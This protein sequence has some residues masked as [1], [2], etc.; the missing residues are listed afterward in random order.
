MIDPTKATGFVRI[1]PK[2]EFAADYSDTKA[3]EVLNNDEKSLVCKLF[4]SQKK[5]ALGKCVDAKTLRSKN[6]QFFLFLSKNLHPTLSFIFKP[7]SSPYPHVAFL[8]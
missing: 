1:V 6:I 2:V 8:K 3:D 4:K 5:S 7:H